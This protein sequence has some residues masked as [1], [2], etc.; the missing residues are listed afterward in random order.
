[1]KKISVRFE[2]DAFLKET[3]VIIRAPE[4][5]DEVRRLMELVSGNRDDTLVVL[6]E[7]ENLHKIRTEEIISASVNGKQMIII[8]IDGCWHLR[9]TLQSLEEKLE[10]GR[11]VR[12]SRFELVNLDRVL[13]YD[14]TVAGTL[15]IELEGGIETW[16]SRRCI[17]AIRKY[18]KE[19][20]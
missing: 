16:A 5:D 11:F 10:A 7:F 18:L 3:E 14:F 6:D 17:P 19:R 4:E 12:I 13:R 8:T 15:R 20:G 1:M 9:Q 2:R